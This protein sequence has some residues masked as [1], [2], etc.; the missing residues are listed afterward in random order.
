[1]C[2]FNITRA[3]K[4]ELLIASFLL[5]IITNSNF[6]RAINIFQFYVLF[7]DLSKNRLTEIGHE[8]FIELRRVKTINLEKNRLTQ[9]LVGSFYDCGALESL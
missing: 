2:V 6:M 8:Y 7:R 5:A 1:M 9:L 4:V 3:S